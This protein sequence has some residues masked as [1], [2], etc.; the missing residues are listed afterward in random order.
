MGSKRRLSICYRWWEWTQKQAKRCCSSSPTSRL[1]HVLWMRYQLIIRRLYR[2]FFCLT[3]P[4]HAPYLLLT[5]RLTAVSDHTWQEIFGPKKGCCRFLFVH[6]SSRCLVYLA[7]LQRLTK[8]VSLFD[9]PP[10]SPLYSR[11]FY[12]FSI[13]V[14]EELG[15]KKSLINLRND[16]VFI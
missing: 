11:S 7:C 6:L 5:S 3:I 9:K 8:Q 15:G 2:H 16:A 13:Q 4:P 12:V 1:S 14:I 10:N